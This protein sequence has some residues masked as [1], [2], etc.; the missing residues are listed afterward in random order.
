MRRTHFTLFV[1]MF[2]AAGVVAGV[3]A[4][5]TEAATLLDLGFGTPFGGAT[6]RSIA[7]GS[8]GVALLHGSDA[9]V[10]NPATLATLEPRVHLDVTV[11]LSQANEDR[12]VPILDSFQG[13]LDDGIIA[14]N[15][16]TYAS[17]EGGIVWRVPVAMP[18]AVGAG[19]FDRFDF[20]YDFF[21][22]VRSSGAPDT[23][24]Q[25]RTLEVAGKLRSISAGYG[26]EVFAG[27]RIG[28]SLHRYFGTV[29]G[30]SGV[31]TPSSTIADTITSL[32]QELSGWGWSAGGHYHLNERVDLAASYDGA[33]DVDGATSSSQ[34]VARSSGTTE[35]TASGQRTVS[36]PGTLRFGVAF[37]PRNELRTVFAVDAARRYWKG[38][39]ETAGVLG[40]GVS[41]RDTWDLGI[42]VEH[43]F[44]N[45]MPLRFGFRYLENYAD[46]ESERSIF[47]AGTAYH[48]AGTM[49]S[50]TGLFHRQTSRQELFRPELIGRGDVKVEDSIVQ[51][52]LGASRRF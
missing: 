9:L 1:R 2:A 27:A 16:N 34:V 51:L 50:V 39:E 45:E 4:P 44:Y 43:V 8:T 47:S 17:G 24:V 48:V 41:L 13:F 20:D 21:Q 42:G 14:I 28:F 38:T 22:E 11:G 29:D 40:Q 10:F 3:L 32:G 25:N 36:Y 23:L 18:M 26:A 46:G 30:R 49:F 15:H 7:M 5:R 19:V 35:T 12:L 33:F 31:E 52:V 37:H 6:P